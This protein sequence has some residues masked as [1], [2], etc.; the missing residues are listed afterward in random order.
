MLA[1]Y[2]VPI[3]LLSMLLNAENLAFLDPLMDALGPAAKAAFLA[4]LPQLATIIFMARRMPLVCPPRRLKCPSCRLKCPSWRLKCR[5]RHTQRRRSRRSFRA[6]PAVVA[7]HAVHVLLGS[8][9]LPVAQHD[10]G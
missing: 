10:V 4:L 7:A 6:L 9:E 2:L 5:S 3:F 1:F 8:D